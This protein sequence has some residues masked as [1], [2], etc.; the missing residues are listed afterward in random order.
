MT[1]NFLASSEIEI[2]QIDPT[3]KCNLRCPQC[4]RIYNGKVIPNLDL[5]E[6]RID[7]YDRIYSKRFAKQIKHSFLNGNFGDPAAA[8][9]LF[10]ATELILQR[11][12]GTINIV[13]NGSLRDEKWWA[14]LA[15]ILKKRGKLTFS[16]DGLDD[17]NHLYRI[18]SNFQSIIRNA[19]SFVAAGGSA[20]W[21]YLVFRHN[22][23]QV[24]EAR[25]VAKQIGFKEFNVKYSKRYISEVGFHKNSIAEDRVKKMDQGEAEQNHVEKTKEILRTHGSWEAYFASA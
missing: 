17:T 24:E 13:S 4:A 11:T 2:I 19:R 15:R 25:A 14:E 20:K 6:L 21:D 12:P 5:T 7:D 18:G 8:T 22:Q 3:S 1:S 9:N 23:H 10:A 16:I